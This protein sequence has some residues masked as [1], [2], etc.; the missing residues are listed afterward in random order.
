MATVRVISKRKIRKF[1]IFSLIFL[2]SL[3]I[4]I[5]I[6]WYFL[7]IRSVNK[8]D[9]IVP[10]EVESNDTYIT[11]AS[12]LKDKNLIRSPFAYKIYIKLHETKSL[13]IG[14]YPLKQNMNLNELIKTINEGPNSELT[15]I[16]ITFPE[17]IHMRKLAS[18]IEKNTSYKASDLYNLLSDTQFLNEKIEQYWFLTDA[19]KN[20]NIYYS[21]EGYLF[22]DTYVFKK[23]ATLKQIVEA[24][25][26]NTSKKLKDYQSAI[27]S[28][29]KS[30][31][32]ILTL[33]SIVELE[34]SKKEDRKKVA[35]VFYNR[36]NRGMGLESDVTTYYGLKKELSD[37]ITGHVYDLNAYN[38]RNSSL[39]G[40]LP[41][42]PICNPSIDSI[43][44]VINY[45]KVDYI[46]FVADTDKKVYFTK[47][48]LEHQKI[49]QKLKEQ[50]KW[51][52]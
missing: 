42:G 32:D 7:N 50:K 28:S 17:G 46:Y 18:I 47:T 12:K 8:N 14:V 13:G 31:H 37:S 10:F 41:V 51:K 4:V 22:P 44:A 1:I 2:I 23:D 16:K 52:A 45:T 25:L 35:G 33:A 6:L 39:N 20:K 43:D 19:I 9:N 36:L 38:T 5:S 49:I 21:L 40:K 24:M 26:E 34:A 3:I 30:V 15:N 48:Y 11:I 27:T 29:K